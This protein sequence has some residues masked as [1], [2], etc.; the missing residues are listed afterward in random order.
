ME[1]FMYKGTCVLGSINMDIIVSVDRFAVPGE[2]LEGLSMSL[3]PGGK[4]ANQAIS[5][6]NM[7]AGVDLIGAVGKDQFGDSLLEHLVQHGV[8]ID[9]VDRLSS[10]TG[11][12]VVTVDSNGE[13]QIVVI[14]ASNSFVLKSVFKEYLA[15]KTSLPRY[16]V[17]QFETPIDVVHSAFKYAAKTGILTVLNPSPIKDIPKHILSL[18]DILILNKVELGYITGEMERVEL[19]D[20]T[21]LI[22]LVVE[23]RRSI[24]NLTVIVTLG[25]SGVIALIGEEIIQQEAFKVE[26]VVDTTGAGDCFCGSLIAFLEKGCEFRKSLQLAQKSAALSVQKF[27]AIPSFPNLESVIRGV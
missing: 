17:S 16:L 8:N 24:G 9:F 25:G 18:T 14:P 12:A 6:A 3:M 22:Q 4:G 26:N 2:T 7:G 20:S 1:G 19:L 5:I 13:N 15:G 11:T 21:K 23:W 27:G 10:N